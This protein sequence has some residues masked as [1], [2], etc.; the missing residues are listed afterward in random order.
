MKKQN[1]QRKIDKKE[2]QKSIKQKTKVIK[3][4]KIVR[5]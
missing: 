3:N 2:L 4:N 5:K 1:R